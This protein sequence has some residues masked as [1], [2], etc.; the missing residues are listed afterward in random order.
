M[1]G[2]KYY[3]YKHTN[4]E[5]GK[6]YIG[7]TC[8]EP[9]QRWRCGR[10]YIKNDHFYRSIQ[11]YGW[12]EGFNHD[13][14]FSGLT[15]KQAMEKE[16]ELI[17]FYDSTNY[18]KG[19]NISTGGTSGAVGVVGER[20]HRYGKRLPEEV[21]LKIKE[22]KAKNPKIYTEEERK[23]VSK[24]VREKYK[25]EE[26]VRKLRDGGFWDG[27][28][29]EAHPMYGRKGADNPNSKKVICLN[30]LEVFASATE[31]SEKMGVNH[32]KLC[33]CCRGLRKSCGKDR[34]GNRLK[35]MYY[36]DYLERGA[37]NED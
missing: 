27:R 9:K 19:Y 30:T 31:A 33:M 24:R 22:T 35:W 26:Y 8:Q 1:K 4:K 16:I 13:V 3:V 14:L 15:Q 25:E 28:K 2:K 29:G 21:I 32:S 34:D 18:N 36:N 20:N 37:I 23:R 11:K 6:V 7:V 17:K 10:G 12:Y 5:N